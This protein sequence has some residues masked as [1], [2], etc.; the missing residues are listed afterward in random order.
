[1]R[2]DI[3]NQILSDLMTASGDIEGAAVV[4]PDGLVMADRLTGDMSAERVGAM[5]A[6]MHSL[7]ERTAGELSRGEIEQV[8]IKADRGYVILTSAGDEAVLTV[9][10]RPGSRIGLVFLEIRRA[11]ERIAEVT[12]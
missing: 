9:L 1:M 11:A 2:G 5:S 6:A 3:L 7:G 4:S 8:M 12:G 10:V